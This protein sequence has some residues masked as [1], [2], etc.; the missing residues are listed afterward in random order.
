VDR[1]PAKYRYNIQQLSGDHVQL[2]SVVVDVLME[3]I[4][5]ISVDPPGNNRSYILLEL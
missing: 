3:Q 4:A 1:S 5:S 2:L